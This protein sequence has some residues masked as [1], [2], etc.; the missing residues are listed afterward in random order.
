MYSDS[1]MSWMES[2]IIE[3][4]LGKVCGKN[5][6]MDESL[7]NKICKLKKFWV[8]KHK[9][10]SVAFLPVL[11]WLA[12]A[13]SPSQFFN[14]IFFCGTRTP[15]TTA[16]KQHQRPKQFGFYVRDCALLS[17]KCCSMNINLERVSLH[18]KMALSTN[19]S[20][21]FCRWRV[22]TIKPTV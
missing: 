13:S 14:F 19:R 15:H 12:I 17:T 8:K 5:I 11:I 6:W 9:L 22:I 1:S 21:P 7:L 2:F 20:W 3:Y 16:N 18:M 10:F 4:Y